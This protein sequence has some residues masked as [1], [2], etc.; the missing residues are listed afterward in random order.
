MCGAKNIGVA[1]RYIRISGVHSKIYIFF[2]TFFDSFVD[3]ILKHVHYKYDNV[4]S[5]FFPPNE[6]LCV[7]HL[8]QLSNTGFVLLALFMYT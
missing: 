5:L 3:Q 4:Y 2:S 1:K 6:K 8:F 7:V